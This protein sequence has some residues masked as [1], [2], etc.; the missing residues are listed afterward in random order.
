MRRKQIKQKKVKK[1]KKK[2]YDHF[3]N[4]TKHCVQRLARSVTWRTRNV[5][6]ADIRISGEWIARK[7]NR[8]YRFSQYILL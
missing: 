4:L 7:Q 8:I 1:K 6:F 5:K 3:I 2:T